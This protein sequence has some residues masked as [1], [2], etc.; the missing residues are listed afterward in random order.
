MHL[1]RATKGQPTPPVHYPA[2]FERGVDPDVENPEVCHAHSAI[3]DEYPPLREILDYQDKVR[4]RLMSVLENEQLEQDRLL[5]EAV[6]IG[7]EHE[8]LHL[9]TFLYMLLQ[10]D[11]TLPP[12]G[13]EAPDFER[14]ALEARNT[15]VPNEWFTI[16]SATFTVGLKDDDLSKLPELSFGW[17][18]EKPQ[19][20]V[21]VSSFSAKGR[22]ITNGEYAAYL[23]SHNLLEVPASWVTVTKDLESKKEQ[24]S[25]TTNGHGQID[26]TDS[27]ISKYAVRTVLGNVPLRWALDWPVMASFDELERYAKWQRCRL[28]TY[29]EVQSIYK[30]AESLKTDGVLHVING[31]KNVR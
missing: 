22:P 17:D 15:A 28:P 4:H 20:A 10:S 21:S 3:P 25:A 6:W 23:K 12:P 7:F 31:E 27:F 29:E 9:E 30:Y 13:L 1:T 2:I 26:G 11:Q 18:N 16:P 5:A 8:T 19:R 24:Q 14:L